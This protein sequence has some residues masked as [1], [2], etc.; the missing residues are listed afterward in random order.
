M[1]QIYCLFLIITVLITACLVHSKN[2]TKT[3][4]KQYFTFLKF[5]K[6]YLRLKRRS[7]T[8]VALEII[9]PNNYLKTGMKLTAKEWKIPK[10]CEKTAPTSFLIEKKRNSCRIFAQA[11]RCN[12]LSF[13]NPHLPIYARFRRAIPCNKIIFRRI[14][15]RTPKDIKKGIVNDDRLRTFRK[16]YRRS[17]LYYPLIKKAN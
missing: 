3:E 1:K 6:K 7:F 12:N 5:K 15:N 10:V 13:L 8:F 9:F 14:D 17:F 4:K 2:F 11:C 16:N